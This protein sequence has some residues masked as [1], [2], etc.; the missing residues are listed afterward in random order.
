[1]DTVVVESEKMKE[2]SERS[3]MSSGRVMWYQICAAHGVG[4]QSGGGITSG[5]EER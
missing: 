3:G 4:L 5:E 1:M 2:A